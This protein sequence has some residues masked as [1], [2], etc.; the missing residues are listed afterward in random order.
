[1]LFRDYIAIKSEPYALLIYTRRGQS[2]VSFNPLK[3]NITLHY[4]QT[5][6]V[7]R[8]KHTLSRL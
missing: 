2:A 6:S 3:R 1:M 5:Q 4:T 7:P 8:S